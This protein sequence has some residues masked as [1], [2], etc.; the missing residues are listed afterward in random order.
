MKPVL[1]IQHRAPYSGEGP[2]EL[3]DA[4]L[5]SAAFGQAVSVLFQDDGV[6]QLLPDQDGRALDRKNLLSQL[7]A[8]GLYEVDKLYVD[9]CSLAERQLKV[10][11]LGLDV[12]ALDAAG[13][14]QLVASHELALRF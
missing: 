8:L 9:A 11:A 6:W 10:E 5:V 2:G 14:Q 1:F 12:T 3:L 13:V 7:K 4:L